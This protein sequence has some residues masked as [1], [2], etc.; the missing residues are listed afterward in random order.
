MADKIVLL[1][2][3]NSYKILFGH[4]K[5]EERSWKINKKNFAFYNK[6][7]RQGIYKTFGDFS[8]LVIYKL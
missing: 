6:Y 5:V 4:I 1:N 8:S 3:L 7:R 2:F